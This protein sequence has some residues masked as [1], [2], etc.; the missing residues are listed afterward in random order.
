MAAAGTVGAS[1]AG[2][3]VGATATFVG[4]LKLRISATTATIS[5]AMIANPPSSSSGFQGEGE[6]MVGCKLAIPG[7]STVFEAAV[8]ADR[9]T[10]EG[11]SGC[12]PWMTRVK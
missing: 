5:S 11:L 3:I 12:S 1:V 6:I 7:D 8:G 9:L 4:R 2:A 10:L